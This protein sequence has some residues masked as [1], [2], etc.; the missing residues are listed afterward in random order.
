MAIY[1]GNRGDKTATLY[2]PGEIV[3]F[4]E[5]EAERLAPMSWRFPRR[6]KRGQ[7]RRRQEGE[8]EGW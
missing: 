6:R 4:S 3:E 2:Q 5:A 1:H 8:G 7:G